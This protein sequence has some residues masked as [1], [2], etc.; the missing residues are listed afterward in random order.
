MSRKTPVLVPLL[1]VSL[2]MMSALPLLLPTPAAAEEPSGPW[3][4]PVRVDNGKHVGRSISSVRMVQGSAGGLYA[5]W[6]DERY[7]GTDCFVSYSTDGGDAWSTDERVDPYDN[8]RRQAPTTCDVEVDDEG[9]V[10]A[11]YA[12]W[13]L[14]QG[15]WRVRFA[16]SD[17]GGD[18]FRDPS[19]AH[20]VVDDAMAQEHPASALSTH[21][22]LN[23]VF[24][25]RTQEYS[26]LFLV[27]SDDGLN[28]LPPRA[29]E[30]G[31]PANVTHV[32]G[33]IA[34]DGD[35]TVYIAYGYR[36]PQEA[37]I[38]LARMVSGSG[39]F[40][41]TKVHTI[42]ED[43]PRSLRPRI[44]V[45]GDVVE[46][47]F[48]PMDADGRIVHLRS[49]DGGDTF[50]AP[51]KV[52]AGGDP[53]AAQSH[54]SLAFD[55]LGRVH[56][57]WAQGIS[58]NTR[59]QHSLS[60]DGVAFT[61]PTRVTGGWNE[62]E[63]GLISW[64]DHP[65]VLPLADG[66]IVA[67][68]AGQLNKTVGVYFA[69]MENL[70]PQ[71]TITSP[72]PGALV[73]GTVYVQGTASDVGTTGLKDV[74][75]KVGDGPA[76]RLQGTTEWEHSFD[77]TAFPDGLLTIKAWA[78][79]GFVEGQEASVQVDVDN[80]HPPVMSL[81]RPV[82]GTKYI[83]IVP[84]DG[85]AEDAEGFGEATVVQWRRDEDGS[86]IDAPSFIKQTD[87]IIDFDFEVDFFDLPTG[88]ASIQVR[89]S[90]G[91]K[92]SPIQTREFEM[93]NKCDLVI[94]D[95]WISIDIVEPEHEDIVTVS[96]TVKN[97][98]AGASGVYEVEMWRFNKFIGRTVGSN[99]SVGESD[100]L[101][102]VW[103]AVKGDNTLKFLVDPAYKVAELDKDNNEATFEVHV[104]SPP[105]EETEGTN[106][107]LI[108]AV[109]VAIA[110]VAIAGVLAFL[111]Y[112][113]TAPALEQPE[114][115]VVYE[116]G[117]M[118]SEGGGEY[119]DADTSG[120]ELMEGQGEPTAGQPDGTSPD[121]PD[122][123]MASSPSP[124]AGPRSWD[125]G[126]PLGTS[127][128]GD[129][130]PGVS[131][132]TPSSNGPGVEPIR[133]IEKPPDLDPGQMASQDTGQLE[134][135]VDFKPERDD[136]A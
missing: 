10:Y 59:V 1:L 61:A 85:T 94:D 82:N 9:H 124:D 108:L 69:R 33:D 71:V 75:V 120:R 35:N 111:K 39:S 24:L 97:E 8:Q 72:S 122:A 51:S 30:P 93:E 78:S 87:T 58:G 41:V 99:L 113:A 127:K 135:D 43:A 130:F 26:K 25:E 80:N 67:A 62:S 76:K 14:Q 2:M 110:V 131:E 100:D 47:V 132:T 121:Q 107:T 3:S 40:T 117:G 68:F 114:V 36:S 115:Q 101:V 73:K 52:W 37:G 83:G 77:S 55:I 103:Q 27:R 128:P 90:D 118:Y 20:F 126:G 54:P 125:D 21:G 16:R 66:S 102:F 44:A 65:S 7:N 95:Q 98:G 15:W 6:L 70:A 136:T 57:M 48:D 88:P 49:T 63:M 4:L 38:K 79:D 12:Q 5:A 50:A 104:A 34:M 119:A 86:W 89:V 11:T 18:S 133:T 92:F 31:Q 17:D 56:V 109:V 81:V 129:V 46:I 29:V 28:P 19:E 64:E 106:W 13:M 123:P 84:V 22:A 32:Q 112:W 105:D 23:I 116:P 42:K 134:Q 60:A 74:F 91:D 96:V 45:W 53:A